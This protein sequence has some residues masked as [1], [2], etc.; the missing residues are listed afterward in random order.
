MAVNNGPNQR[1]ALGADIGALGREELITLARAVCGQAA[2]FPEGHGN[3]HPENIYMSAD[4]SPWLGGRAEHAPGEWTTDELEYMAPELFWSG[5]GGA[6]ADVY[7]IGL[8]LYAGVTRGRLPFFA[9][10][11][12]EMTNELRAAALRR[13]MNGESVPVPTISGEVL[14]EVLKK[15]LA[16]DPDER[17]ADT[18]ELSMALEPCVGEGDAAAQAMFG[19]KESELSEVER[20]MAAILA[21]YGAEDAAAVPEPQPEPEPQTEP[22]PEPEPEPEAR[23]PEPEPGTEEPTESGSG[24]VA[25]AEEAPEA[26]ETEERPGE[27]RAEPGEEPAVPESRPKETLPERERKRGLPAFWFIA[28]LCVLAAAAAL[29][30]NFVLPRVFPPEPVVPA[31]APPPSVLPAES[32]APTPSATPAATPSPTPSPS[33]SPAGPAKPEGSEYEI[34]TGDYSWTEAEQLCR[35]MGGHLAVIDDED[36]LEYIASLAEAEGLDFLWIGFYRRDGNFY[37]VDNSPGYYAWAPGEPSN[38]DTDGTVESYGLLM[39]TESLWLYN[40]SR[41]DPA[42]LYPSIYSG[43]TGFICEYD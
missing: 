39:K 26:P 7:S 32:A 8:L 9:R 23:T 4:G 37:W 11:A 1:R 43:Q 13:R 15:C 31:T 24:P 28:A 19:K 3:I 12:S 10:P 5:T 34:V 22:E 18:I 42:A 14:G 35:E 27:D 38:F 30:M 40:D 36:E 2:A 41:N 29:I 16:F 33:P 25:P 17:Y 21:S 6:R 20:T